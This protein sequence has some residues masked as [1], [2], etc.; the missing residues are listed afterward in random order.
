MKV[1]S[2][3]LQNFRSFVDSGY[4]EFG[5]INVLIGA[6]NS[7][8]SSILRGLHL[9]QVGTASLTDV[10]SGSSTADVEMQLHT[11]FSF[12]SI[13]NIPT[14]EKFCFHKAKLDAQTDGQNGNIRF[15]TSFNDI[16]GENSSVV[17]Q[18]HSEEPNHVIVPFLSNRKTRKYSEEV[19]E[20]TVR[21]ISSEMT[22]LAAKLFRLGNTE[23]PEHG[24]YRAACKEILGFVVTAIPSPSGQ[25]L[26]IYL[27]DGSTLRIDQLGEGVPNIVALLCN[28]IV[29]RHKLFLIEELENDLH[30]SALKALLDL[31][32]KSS[33]H[34]QF[35]I[36]THSNIVVTH[37]CAGSQSRLFQVSTNKESLPTSAQITLVAETPD[38]RIRVLQ[39]LGYAFSDFAL[40]DGWLFLEES[41][42]ERLI[43]DY[44]IPWFA[45][46]LKRLR[47]IATGGIST[48][49][50]AFTDFHRLMLFTHLEPAYLGKTWVRV[51]GDEPGKAVVAALHQK[52]PTIPKSNVCHYDQSQFEHYYPDRFRDQANQALNIPDKQSKRD[53]KKKLLETVL[54]WIKEDEI[55]A[56]EELRVSASEVIDDLSK[57]ESELLA[58]SGAT[59]S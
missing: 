33:E 7:G 19:R 16:N 37:L 13:W 17:N 32:I 47:T 9:L 30:P 12:P 56:R 57:I 50:P 4:I 10:R 41:S 40:W 35:V 27:P 36:S 23:F 53:A 15:I 2:I 22:H 31:I 18:L 26:G 58:Q 8:K 49:E 52:F 42:A 25:L 21:V 38:A 54:E 34:N 24:E 39:E 28:L 46:K 55:R 59:Q 3:R 44:L 20:G 1:M 45:P 6:N 14:Q 5:Q 51:D 11:A 48:V 29:S 43:R